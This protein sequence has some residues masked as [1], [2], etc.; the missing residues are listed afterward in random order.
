MRVVPKPLGSF[1]AG[2]SPYGAFDMVG[3][4]WQWC[5]DWYDPTFYSSRIACDQNPENRNIGE[6]KLRVLRG[7]SWFGM[8]SV[9][10]RCA[11]RHKYPPDQTY[12]GLGF[13]CVTIR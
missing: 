8:F 5:S 4:I 1:P 6:Q 2:V 9:D 13:R 7:G 3:N 12:F 10:F 11:N